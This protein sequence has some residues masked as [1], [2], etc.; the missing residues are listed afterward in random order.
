VAVEDN[1]YRNLVS[2]CV[3][4]NSLK[5]GKSAASFLR[6]L[7]RERKLTAGELAAGLQALND[8]VAGKLRPILPDLGQAGKRLEP[9]SGI[10]DSRRLTAKRKSQRRNT[11]GTEIEH[12][13]HRE[14]KSAG[15]M[16]N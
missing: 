16:R 4:C 12:G 3:E 10:L 15:T 9:L 2:C 5:R 11:E 8:L 1:S 6:W 14:E 7:H 13:G